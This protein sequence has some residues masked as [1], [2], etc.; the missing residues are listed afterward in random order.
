MKRIL[1]AL[2]LPTG[3]AGLDVGVFALT[4]GRA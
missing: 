4:G 2:V 1:R 3:L